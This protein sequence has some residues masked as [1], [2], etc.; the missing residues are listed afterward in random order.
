M[1]TGGYMKF[2]NMKFILLLLAGLAVMSGCGDTIN[3]ST[4]TTST[5]NKLVIK[6]GTFSI[7]S[8][9]YGLNKLYGVSGTIAYE[10]DPQGAALYLEA[11]KNNLLF[12]AFNPTT[13]L[14]PNKEMSFYTGYIDPNLH[15]NLIDTFFCTLTDPHGND[16]NKFQLIKQ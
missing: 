15:I 16:S 4:A 1:F 3:N 10:G 8:G 13:T 14:I 6:S 5:S 2:A 7:Y 9:T 11:M 12:Y